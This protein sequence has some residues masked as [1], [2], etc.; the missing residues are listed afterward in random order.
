[1]HIVTIIFDTVTEVFI[2]GC[3]LWTMLS[4][5]GI[6]RIAYYNFK[7]KLCTY[8]FNNTL[9]LYL[10]LIGSRN[11]FERDFTIELN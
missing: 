3:L 6:N 10:L 5:F 7:S 11:G 8:S 1:M 2:S 4:V 9:I